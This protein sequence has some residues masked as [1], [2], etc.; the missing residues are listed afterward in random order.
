MDMECW[1]FPPRYD[2]SYRPASSSRYWFPVRETMPAAERE[3]A[4]LE[5]LQE[6]CR[7]A[8]AHSAFYRKKW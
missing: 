1:A 5:R 3:R 8:Y 6:V 4:I 7:Y 2:A